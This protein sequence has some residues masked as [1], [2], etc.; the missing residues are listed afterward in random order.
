MKKKPGFDVLH[1]SLHVLLKGNITVRILITSKYPF[2]PTI[3]IITEKRLDLHSLKRNAGT[4]RDEMN[5]K[6][7]KQALKLNLRR[8]AR[9]IFKESRVSQINIIRTLYIR[10][11]LNLPTPDCASKARNW[12][13]I[14]SEEGKC[15]LKEGQQKIRRIRL[16]PGRP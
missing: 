16:L 6:I 4:M 15:L 1:F 14:Q 7:C 11:A 3:I 10:R 13:I 9:S 2:K 12:T 5:K 8:H